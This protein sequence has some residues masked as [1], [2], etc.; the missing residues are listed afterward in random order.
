MARLVNEI[1]AKRFVQFYKYVKN[2]GI[3][4]SCRIAIKYLDEE[5]IGRQVAKR[6]SR[7]QSYR[8]RKIL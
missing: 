1:N 8:K 2:I 6:F 3:Y 5:E 7:A 4:R